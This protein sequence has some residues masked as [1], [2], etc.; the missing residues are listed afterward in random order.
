[1]LDV[2]PTLRRG[3]HS[4]ATLFSVK[5]LA[6]LADTHINPCGPSA[7]SCS[8]DVAATR[9]A[10]VDAVRAVRRAAIRAPQGTWD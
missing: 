1:L 7:A 9:A 6:S 5:W 8:V 2:K 4:D 3:R 10:H